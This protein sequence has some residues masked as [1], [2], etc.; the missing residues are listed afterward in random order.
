MQS[1]SMII[2]AISALFAL[3]P[4][5]VSQHGVGVDIEG[6]LVAPNLL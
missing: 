5:G 6:N 4:T 1:R 3:A 2:V